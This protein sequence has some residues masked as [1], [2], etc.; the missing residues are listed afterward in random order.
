M[1]RAT[2]GFVTGA[3]L[4]WFA[5]AVL[6]RESPSPSAGSP[7]AESGV[8]AP[9]PSAEEAALRSEI[10]RLEARLA[11][12]DVPPAPHAASPALTAAERRRRLGRRVG[13]LIRPILEVRL[14]L[15]PEGQASNVEF[16][17]WLEA[18]AAESGLEVQEAAWSPDGIWSYV[19]DVLE[20]ANPPLTEAERAAWDRDVAAFRADWARYLAARPGLSRLERAAQTAQ[21]STRL[22]RAMYADFTADHAA[23]GENAFGSMTVPWPGPDKHLD[24]S[25]TR[26]EVRNELADRWSGDLGLDASQR[27]SL[28]AAIDAYINQYP[29]ET[30]DLRRRMEAREDVEAE[31]L[32]AQF[33]L[34]AG[35]QKSIAGMLT[36]RPDQRRRLED[37]ADVYGIDV[38]GQ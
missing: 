31:L 25:G 2:A 24:V 6:L 38:E 18:L 28:L 16:Q 5:A 29:I 17:L 13:A 10:A 19:R 33:R 11:A 26:E 1:L 22:Y 36:L 15:T 23:A 27:A 34:M 9:G 37:W 4:A 8:A 30:R 7:E 21:L 32:E 35:A 14:D 20:A 3:L 12:G